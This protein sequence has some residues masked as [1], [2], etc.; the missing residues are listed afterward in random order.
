MDTASYTQY[1]FVVDRIVPCQVSSR[2]SAQGVDARLKALQK[3]VRSLVRELPAGEHPVSRLRHYGPTALSSAELVA[4]VLQT[5][6]AL[7]L[8]QELL[9]H[10]EGLM[11]LARASIS[12][13]CTVDGIGPARAAQLK[14]AL[15]L[16]RRLLVASPEERPQIRSPADAANLLM[17]E[18]ST[19]DQEHLRILILDTK[20]HLMAV[21]NLYKGSLNT[22]LIR[23]GEVFKRAVKENAAAVIILHNHSSGDPTPSPEDV[24]VTEQIVQAGKLLD[25]DVLDHIILGQQKFVSLKERGLG[26]S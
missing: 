5:P 6:D 23:V 14:A 4:A 25:I 3:P 10:F 7:S 24:R 21:E 13:L 16:G 22:S 18:M 1:S 19:L 20:N 17:L 11:G 9:A 12:E 8:A 15:E 26:F 2:G